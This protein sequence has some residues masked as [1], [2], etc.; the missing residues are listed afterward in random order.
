M[1]RRFQREARVIASVYPCEPPAID[2]PFDGWTSFQLA[3]CPKGTPPQLI[4]VRDCFQ[5]TND[6][7]QRDK[8][9][10]TLIT[11][12]QVVDDLL[13]HW[14][15]TP[16]GAPAGCGPG[17]GLIAG[18]TPTQQEIEAL[19]ERQT[20]LFDYLFHEGQ[21]LSQEHDWRNITR[22]H[23]MAAEWLDLEQ[24]WARDLKK[25]ATVPCPACTV[26]IAQTAYICP[27]CHTTIRELPPELAA[28]QP[29]GG[30]GQFRKSA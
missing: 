17:I 10:S 14:A 21:R 1:S 25:A 23:R 5:V 28:I 6:P 7:M 19:I 18:H 15:R 27:F 12:E 13:T 20:V 4:E 22:H 3:A 16:I 30:A 8:Q 29:K 2:R 11:W 9:D 26:P 24:P